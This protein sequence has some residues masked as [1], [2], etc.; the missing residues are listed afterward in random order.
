M[1]LDARTIAAA[2]LVLAPLIGAIPIA[3]PPLVPVWSA[4]RERHIEIIGTH[5]RSWRLLNAGFSLA[6]LGTGAGVVAL[7]VAL[8]DDVTLAATVGALAAVY[9][10]VGVLW[11]VVLA[12]RARTTPALY[13]LGAMHAEPGPAEV[14]VGAATGGV[15]VAF[16]L[17]TAITLLCLCAVLGLAG[18]VPVIVAVVAGLV[19]GV[20]LGGQL[21]TGDTIPAVLYLPTMLVGISLLAGWG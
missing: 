14:L 1:T 4:T 11:C 8:A 5:R 17:G 20:S 3:Y 21:V 7:A 13:D 10:A 6:T 2:L 15:F 16:A 18:V 12:I 9:L 19:A